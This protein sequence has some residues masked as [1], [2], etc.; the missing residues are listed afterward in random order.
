VYQLFLLFP[1]AVHE[2]A[3]SNGVALRRQSFGDPCLK[4]LA[5]LVYGL[6]NYGSLFG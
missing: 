2:P 3:R 4:V 6:D 1:R 5:K